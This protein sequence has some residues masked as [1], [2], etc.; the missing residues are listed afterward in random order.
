MPIATINPATGEM[1]RSFEALTDS[2]I[3]ERLQWAAEEYPRFRKS[4]VR[5]ARGDDEQ[6]RGDSGGRERGA[7]AG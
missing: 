6:G 3:E 5:P 2:Q 4:V 1:L 7:R